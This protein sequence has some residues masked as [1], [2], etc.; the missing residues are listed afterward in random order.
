M[1]PLFDDT[2]PEG[3]QLL[4]DLLRQAPPWR[5]MELHAQIWHTVRSLARC[6]LQQRFPDA[7]P[8]ELHR[9]MAD[10]LLG[11]EQAFLA[12]GPRGYESASD[13]L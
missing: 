9:R 7:A 12:Y 6:G 4:L 10:L 8:E 11:P 5:R 1:S 13:A 3:E 2:S